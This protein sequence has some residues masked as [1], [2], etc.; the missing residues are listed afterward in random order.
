MSQSD[1]TWG[2]IFQPETLYLWPPYTVD[3]TDMKRQKY[4]WSM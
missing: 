3:T 1:L 2:L 4:A